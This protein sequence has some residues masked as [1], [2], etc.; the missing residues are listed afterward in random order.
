MNLFSFK[1]LCGL[2]QHHRYFLKGKPRISWQSVSQNN[3]YQFTSG[4]ILSFWCHQALWVHHGEL[5]LSSPR[6]PC[7][8]TQS[9][10]R[11][12]LLGESTKFNL[13]DGE[14]GSAGVCGQERAPGTRCWLSLQQ[15][16]GDHQ[17]CSLFS[18]GLPSLHGIA[19]ILELDSY[20][21]REDD[22]GTKKRSHTPSLAVQ[23]IADEAAEVKTWEEGMA[24]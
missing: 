24:S 12:L 1:G 15:V 22:Q 16:T 13:K 8:L 10:R 2:S 5:L 3:K 19:Q 17:W 11:S 23:R 6:N 9:Y 18:P 7:C 4:L 14:D 21:V 20:A